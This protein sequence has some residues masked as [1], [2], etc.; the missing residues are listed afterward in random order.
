MKK[1]KFFCSFCDSEN[2]KSVFERLCEVVKSQIYGADKEVYFTI[3]EDYTHV[4]IINTA[5]PAI[6]SHIPKENVIGLAYE[7]L[8]YLNLTQNFVNYA[9]KNISRYYIGDKM[10]LPN[11]FVE[12]YGYMWHVTPLQHIPEKNKK[13]SIMVSQK[14]H[15][16]GHKY[17]HVLVQ[18][19]LKHELPIDI[20]GR[21]CFKYS[22]FH[23]PYIRGN[24]ENLEPY[25]NYDFHIAIENV[26]SNHYFSEK[27]VNP[28]LCSTTP[29]YWG[30][31]N[32][33]EYFDDDVICLTGDVQKD[34]ELIVDVLRNPE[35]YKKNIDVDF[36]KKKTS[37]LENI[38]TVFQ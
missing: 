16:F 25:E 18:N 12:H 31:K 27:I 37:L 36:V 2:C 33:K 35:K 34:L 3:D 13:M 9:E 8:I 1:I 30:C 7:P 21:G 32:I 38:E 28:M 15:T 11:T 19:I 23:S 24:F 22:M 20:Y 26:Q 5:M 17:R 4:I 14:M 6:P 10:N 29:I